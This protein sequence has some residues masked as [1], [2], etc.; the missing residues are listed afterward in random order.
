MAL[1]SS[2]TTALF[3]PTDKSGLYEYDNAAHNIPLIV[4]V[5]SDVV[6]DSV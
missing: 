5:V 2:C 3:W 6:F 4:A 1:T